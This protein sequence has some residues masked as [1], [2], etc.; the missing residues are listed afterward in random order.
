MSLYK[1]LSSIPYE[2]FFKHNKSDIKTN[3]IEFTFLRKYTKRKQLTN[4]KGSRKIHCLCM[5]FLLYLNQDSSL[6]SSCRK[7]LYGEKRSNK[8]IGF[9]AY[10]ALTSYQYNVVVET[11]VLFSGNIK[12]PMTEFSEGINTYCIHPITIL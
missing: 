2:S 6:Y 5:A 3:Q 4:T 8:D 11:Y 10:E 1:E 12:K 7:D 9:R